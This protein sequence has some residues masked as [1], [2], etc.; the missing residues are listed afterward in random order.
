MPSYLSG[1][2]VMRLHREALREAPEEM[3]DLANAE[4]TVDACLG[5][6]RMA[7]EYEGE[8]A[9][10]LYYAAALLRNIATRHSFK[11]GNKR[12]AWLCCSESLR[13]AG[14]RIV[15]EVAWAVDLGERIVVGRLGLDDIVAELAERVVT[16][17][18]S[19]RGATASVVAAEGL[20]PNFIALE[21]AP[22]GA[23]RGRR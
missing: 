5:G 16:F 22:D 8:G 11:N 1:E 9:P 19:D 23:E 17:E 15:C 10:D 3:G 4:A 18:P 14:L 21:R 7:A 6:A 13:R 12:T 20:L 2:D